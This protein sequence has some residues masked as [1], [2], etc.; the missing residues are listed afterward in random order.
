MLYIANPT[1]PVSFVTGASSALAQ[2]EFHSLVHFYDEL[3]GVPGSP[4]MVDASGVCTV[5][6]WKP[7][8]TYSLCWLIE[9]IIKKI[10]T[11]VW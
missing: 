5:Y 2:K 10:T 3:P 6:A 1:D 8:P 4:M 11:A 9:W 7:R